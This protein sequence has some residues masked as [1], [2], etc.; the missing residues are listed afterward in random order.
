MGNVVPR[1]CWTRARASKCARSLGCLRAFVPPCLR[2]AV[3]LCLCASAPFFGGCVERRISITSE[4]AGALVWVND[5]EVGRTPVETVYKHYG[6]YDVRLELDGHDTLQTFSKAK[7]PWWEFPG[8]D[9][10]A[11]AIPNAKHTVRWHFVLTPTM[12]TTM[13]REQFERELIERAHGLRDQMGEA[14]PPPATESGKPEAAPAETAP[15][16]SVGVAAPGGKADDGLKPAD[17]PDDN[18]PGADR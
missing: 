15:D 2:A 18:G 12:S 13:D 10:I 4:P 7:T 16:G 6:E 14:P 8:P 11:E 17:A 1:A 9:L 5:V 3:P